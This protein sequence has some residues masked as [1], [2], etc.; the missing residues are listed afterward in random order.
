[1][2]EWMGILMLLWLWAGLRTFEVV[3]RLCDYLYIRD[4]GFNSESLA[5]CAKEKREA[6]NCWQVCLICLVAWP[7]PLF[8]V[9]SGRLE[10][11][12]DRM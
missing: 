2:P 6:M 9:K 8:E 10:A 7:W 11:E 3:A 4:Q 5:F 12:L 1:M